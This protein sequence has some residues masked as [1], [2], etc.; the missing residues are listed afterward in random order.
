MRCRQKSPNNWKPGLTYDHIG[1]GV[2]D[3]AT[4]EVVIQAEAGKRRGAW[5]G[6][7]PLARPD[8][9]RGPQL[10]TWRHTALLLRP[11]VR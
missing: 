3:Y 1:I 6:A 2:L 9:P 7:F 4:R 11:T 10:A 8:R 5:G